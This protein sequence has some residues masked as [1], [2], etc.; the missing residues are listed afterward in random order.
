MYGQNDGLQ[1]FRRATKPVL[2]V[3]VQCKVEALRYELGK[4]IHYACRRS[5]GSVAFGPMLSAAEAALQAQESLLRAVASPKGGMSMGINYDETNAMERF[6]VLEAIHDVLRN[7]DPQVAKA[8]DAIESD[9]DAPVVNGV[10]SE[11]SRLLEDTF[12]IA[13]GEQRPRWS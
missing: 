9:P 1:A 4:A 13:Y 5:Y 10:L 11:A 2:E 7:L 3:A 6:S 8:T 12:K